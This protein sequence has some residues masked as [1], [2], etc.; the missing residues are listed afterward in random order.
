MLKE[1]KILCRMM[2]CEREERREKLFVCLLFVFDKMRGG[3]GRCDY[4]PDLGGGNLDLAVPALPTIDLLI[5]V[6]YG[7]RRSVERG[8]PT[9]KI[10]QS[11]RG[12]SV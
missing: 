10:A 12:K 11:C 4:L 9:A 6:T 5:L 1:L 7:S 8:T 2:N 3:E